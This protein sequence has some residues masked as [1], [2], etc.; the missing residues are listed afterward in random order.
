MSRRHAEAF[1]YFFEILNTFT[2]TLVKLD[3]VIMLLC[4][5]TFELGIKILVM[6]SQH[7]T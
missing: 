6:D 2:V 3:Q 5:E 7:D 1:S 4:P